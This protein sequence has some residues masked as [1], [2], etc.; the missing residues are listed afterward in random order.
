MN[1]EPS[2]TR[3]FRPILQVFQKNVRNM[4]HFRVLKREP[5]ET[6]KIIP[7]VSICKKALFSFLDFRGRIHILG[8]KIVE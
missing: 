2:E 7:A 3:R 8:R 1:C 6:Q 5:I 4:T